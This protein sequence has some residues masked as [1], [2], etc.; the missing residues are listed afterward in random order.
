[1]KKIFYTIEK[2]FSN[3]W[4]PLLFIP[5]A[6]CYL[7]LYSFST[8][9]FFIRE[10]GDSAIFKIMGLAVLQGRIPYR[11]IF[12]HKGPVLYLIE[13]L[14]QWMIPGRNGILMLQCLS[15]SITLMFL[16]KM[17]KL[18]VGNVLSFIWVIVALCIMGVFFHDGNMTEEWNLPY[19][20][21]PLY[22]A[23]S[24]LSNESGMFHPN[25]YAFLYGLCFGMA[26][27]IRPNDAVAQ[28]GGVMFGVIV[29]LFYRKAYK[30]I[31]QNVLFFLLGLLIIAIPILIWFGINGA[32]GDLYFGLLEFNAK[33]S[34]GLLY[35]IRSAIGKDKL[36]FFMF[37]V[38]LVV[39]VYNTSYKRLL[40][41]LLPLLS[42][43]VVF[44]GT[45]PY[46][47]YHIVVIQYFMLFFVFLCLQ[48]N[49]SIIICSLAM[50][51]ASHIDTLKTA[52]KTPRV[53]I[54][55]VVSV[56]KT[57]QQHYSPFYEEKDS[58]FIVE[59][60]KV[61]KNVP[62]MDRDSIWNYNLEFDVAM[63]WRQGVTQVNK[64]TL[65]SMYKLD[66]RLKKDD[67]I[68]LKQPKYVLFSE[69]HP[70]DSLDYVFIMTHY[71]LVANTDTTVCKI[72]LYR[73]K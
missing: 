40:F 21:V 23:L 42:L 31:F 73:K 35:M 24:Y 20:I 55:Y 11:D 54:N 4:F 41:L 3:R 5:I 8:S 64:V 50:M 27:F 29:W 16:F 9:P 68:I 25:K 28:V 7:L 13:A 49:K 53:I 37:F 52:R 70:R 56:I 44:T 71:D 48:Q 30:N 1:M 26:F 33:Y 6:V 61:F 32:L 22:F 59:T 46:P 65:Y 63:L 60:N 2:V 58:L 14:G 18:F 17:A 69:E 66:E 12:D 38:V 57:G 43:I 10:G 34:D 51:I 72:E 15:M 45:R 62:V 19:L 67:D 39:M 47:H 36:K